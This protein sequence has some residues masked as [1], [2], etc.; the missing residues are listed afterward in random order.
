MAWGLAMLSVTLTLVLLSAPD[1]YGWAVYAG[2]STA[3]PDFNNVSSAMQ[4]SFRWSMRRPLIR[5]AM[6]PD[7]CSAMHPLLIENTVLSFAV[8]TPWQNFTTCDRIHG[9]LRDAFATWSQA[10]SAFHFVDVTGRCESERM[11][12]PIADDRCAESDY[13]LELENATEVGDFYV[14]WKTES[15]PLELLPAP[16]SWLCSQRTCWEC[17]RA[18]VL[19]G[20]FTQKNR[21]L[22]DL[23]AKA[24]VQRT[25]VTEQPPLSPHGG[26]ADGK[27][28]FR[29]W[30]EFNVDDVYKNTESDGNTLGNATVDNCYR[31]DNDVCDYI[32]SLP[33]ADLQPGY[34]T[35]TAQ[36]AYPLNFPHA[37]HCSWSHLAPMLSL[38]YPQ[39][40]HNPLVLVHFLRSLVRLLV[41][42][43]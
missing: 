12:R 42:G 4:S 19:I 40:Q 3:S 39:W 37:S 23:H 5:W 31:I 34:A 7:F 8:K 18:D 33:G 22:G 27:T 13:C 35:S 6:T 43:D 30:L 29:A 11:W 20:G 15:T 24:R 25:V 36:S 17:D 38:Q 21:Q 26:G 10:N 2:G 14:D 41:F 9:I 28:V 32:V 1:C 16:P